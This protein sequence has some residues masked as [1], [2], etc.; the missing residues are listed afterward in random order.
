M[1][2]VRAGFL[3][4]SILI[5]VVAAMVVPLPFVAERPGRTLSLAACVDVEHEQ[6]SAVHGD[7]LLMTISVQGSTT[8][9]A[10]MAIARDDVLLVPRQAVIPTGTDTS[11]YFRDQRAAFAL[12]AD[13]AAAVGLSAAGLPADI[14]GDGVVVVTTQPGTPAHGVLEPGDLIRAVND[15]AI[16]DEA[17]LRTSISALTDGEEAV[18]DITRRGESA[19]V[20]VTPTVFE[21]RRILG[22]QPETENPRVELPVAVDVAAGAIGG[23]SAGLMIA[24]TVYDQVLPGVDLAGGRTIAGTGTIDDEGRV[25]PIGGAGL[26]VIAAAR[27]GA[28]IFLSPAANYAEASAA[29]PSGSD[30]KVVPVETL[31]DA[32]EAIGEQP[33]DGDERDAV[34][35]QPCPYDAA[36]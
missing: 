2:W 25:G 26:K 33:A 34:E 6:A 19:Q 7:F 35:E 12:M 13:R 31:D 36:A 23:P 32:L 5:L 27:A 21:G 29:L 11:T 20:R 28:D 16:E 17:D 8:V 10:L 24:L 14:T 3:P 4:V 18:L 30:L 22:V 15:E 1:R 9:E